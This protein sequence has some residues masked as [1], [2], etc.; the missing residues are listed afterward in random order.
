[1]TSGD[2]RHGSASS[3]ATDGQW[4]VGT[5]PNHLNLVRAI[6]ACLVILSHSYEIKTGGRTEELL[7][8]WTG[9]ITFGALAVELFFLISGYLILRSWIEEPVLRRFL[10]KRIRR[11]Y[12]GFLAASVVTVMTCGF[13]LTAHHSGWGLTGLFKFLIGALTLAQ[14]VVPFSFAG[15]HYPG[16]N[17]PLWSIRYEFICYLMVPLLHALP[18]RNKAMI[19]TA[20][21]T[22]FGLAY[23][24][25]TGLHGDYTMSDH[26]LLAKSFIRLPMFFFA[27][28]LFYFI[29]RRTR[30]S[31]L[32]VLTSLILL[33]ASFVS[34]VLVEPSLALFGGY[35]LF[36][37]AW[38]EYGWLA[39]YSRLPDIS[40]GTYLYGWP[41]SKLL[42][43]YDPSMSA[44]LNAT[45]SLGIAIFCGY[46]SWT[47]VEGRFLAKRTR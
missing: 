28:G 36:S 43:H 6:L 19:W 33:S 30:P 14:P 22:L 7:H 47:L 44:G 10:N 26:A 16:I 17:V 41:V 5:G 34:G 46:L 4:Q 1:M 23:I 38:L 24:Y 12:P 32:M 13:V 20:S 9:S 31:R 8:R 39:A 15:T 11:I 21:F 42:Y 18:L 35:A 29:F 25:G 40:Y 3:A 45:F 37:L 2:S 27:G